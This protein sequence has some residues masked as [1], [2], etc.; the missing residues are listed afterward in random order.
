MN[1]YL[2]YGTASSDP[3]NPGLFAISTVRRVKP[4]K[5]FKQNGTLANRTVVL[6]SCILSAQADRPLIYV[7]GITKEAPVQKIVLP[8]KL[9]CI[10]ATRSGKFLAAGTQTGKLILWELGSGACLIYK[11]IHYGSVTSIVFSADDA[12][13]FSAGADSRIYSWRTFDLC[14]MG[15]NLNEL[16]PLA[17]ATQHS[18]EITGLYCG[19]GGALDS[20]LYSIS[21]DSSCRV[22]DASDL[23]LYTTYVFE[24]PLCSI[25]VDP[26]ER[27]IYVGG[28]S[29]VIYHVD[30]YR[31][32]SNGSIEYNGGL[33]RTVSVSSDSNSMFS[34]HSGKILALA[35]TFDATM[36]VSG[37]ED[38]SVIVWDIATHQ[39]L[40]VNRLGRGPVHSV[41][42]LPKLPSEDL[43]PLESFK[44]LSEE[45]YGSTHQSWMQIPD[46]TDDETSCTFSIANLTETPIVSSTTTGPSAESQ[47]PTSEIQTK[48]T[49]DYKAKFERVS[50][51][52]DKL[53]KEHTAML[54]AANDDA[55][56]EDE[57]DN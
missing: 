31:S 40:N 25:V 46:L 34:G 53:W 55:D 21:R 17:G 3:K 52:Y 41:N 13:L 24:E 5:T 56:D 30:L 28:E 51:A 48:E 19:Y 47:K 8:E 42:V 10:T 20:R 15:M 36:L 2:V 49:D 39:S 27:A 50:A 1:E 22:W 23:K 32:T 44:F 45:S 38:G 33:Q 14:T 57:D 29:G 11:E 6:D 35:L 43:L 16:K 37:S 4:F 12:V 54:E 7:Y 18:L 26:A 9:S